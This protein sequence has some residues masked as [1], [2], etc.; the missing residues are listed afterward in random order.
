MTYAVGEESTRGVFGFT[1]MIMN[2]QSTHI[3]ASR[4]DPAAPPA[5]FC[6]SLDS[7]E[8]SIYANIFDLPV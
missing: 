4:L 6:F 5:I 7:A 8:T 2:Q 3:Y 1:D